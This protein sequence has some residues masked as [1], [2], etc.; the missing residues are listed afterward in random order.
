LAPRNPALKLQGPSSTNPRASHVTPPA[1]TI[2]GHEDNDRVVRKTEFLQLC[3]QSADILIDIGHR[4]IEARPLI[5]R[6]NVT[7]L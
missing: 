4:A 7:T 1:G 5:R 2:V 3:P 6:R